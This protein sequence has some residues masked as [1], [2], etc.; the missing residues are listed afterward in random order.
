MGLGK[1]TTN[2]DVEVLKTITEKDYQWVYICFQSTYSWKTIMINEFKNCGSRGKARINRHWGID[3]NESCQLYLGTYPHIDSIDHFTQKFC[4]K[5]R[6][7]KYWHF[8]MIHASIWNI[9]W[10]FRVRN[11]IYMEGLFP[12]WLLDIQGYPIKS[13]VEVTPPLWGS[14]LAMPK[15]VKLHNKMDLHDITAQPHQ[16]K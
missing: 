4:M 2:E 9:T 13:N 15:W 3:M 6:I 8:P 11:W 1:T 10:V 16:G 12:R 7:W 14:T 5:Y